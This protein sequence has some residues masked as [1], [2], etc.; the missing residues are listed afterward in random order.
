MI[1]RLRQSDTPLGTGCLVALT[2]SSSA[3][4][5]PGAIHEESE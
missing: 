4:A 2:T 3:V 5:H 1:G